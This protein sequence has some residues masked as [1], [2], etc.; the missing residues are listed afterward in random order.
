MRSLD[1][2]QAGI[3]ELELPHC[4]MVTWS[5]KYIDTSFS[6]YIAVTSTFSSSCSYCSSGFPITI[7][8]CPQQ[9]AKA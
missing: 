8:G 5:S 3:I 1:I 4:G 9:V 7:K 6:R 2:S